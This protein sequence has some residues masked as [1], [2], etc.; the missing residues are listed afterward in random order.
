MQMKIGKTQRL[1]SFASQMDFIAFFRPEKGNNFQHKMGI[2]CTRPDDQPI[3]RI[4]CAAFSWIGWKHINDACSLSFRLPLTKNA[5]DMLTVIRSMVVLNTATFGEFLNKTAIYLPNGSQQMLCGMPPIS[6]GPQFALE[7]SAIGN[8]CLGAVAAAWEEN[9]KKINIFH[10]CWSSPTGTYSGTID[11][12]RSTVDTGSFRWWRQRSS[13]SNMATMQPIEL[14]R[15]ELS[16]VLGP[17]RWCSKHGTHFPQS[18]RTVDGYLVTISREHMALRYVWVEHIGRYRPP[19]R[20]RRCH[21][22]L[23][24]PTNCLYDSIRQT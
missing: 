2:N 12:R 9:R 18:M 7:K 1:Q 3:V 19:K 17:N 13:G 8:D 14:I 11:H 24:M 20:W 4:T 15:S 23:P 6:F 22:H 16:N 10:F 21:W 5:G